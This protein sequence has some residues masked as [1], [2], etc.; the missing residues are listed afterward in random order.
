MVVDTQY[1]CGDVV[2]VEV[3]TQLHCDDVVTVQWSLPG[4]LGNSDYI[5]TVVVTM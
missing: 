1:H 5:V 2:T 3:D 4:G